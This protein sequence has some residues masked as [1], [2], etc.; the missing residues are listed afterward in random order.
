MPFGSRLSLFFPVKMQKLRLSTYINCVQSDK[1]KLIAIE[2][3]RNAYMKIV[4]KNNMLEE[5]IKAGTQY[6]DLL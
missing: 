5:K 2:E 4:N 1:P 6:I 3:A